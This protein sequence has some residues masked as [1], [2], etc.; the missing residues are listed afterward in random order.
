METYRFQIKR[1]L[2]IQ[3]AGAR[4]SIQIALVVSRAF[5]TCFEYHIVYRG[6]DVLGI[7]GRRPRGF[8]SRSACASAQYVDAQESSSAANVFVN[9]AYFS[10]AA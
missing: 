3:S 5:V 1:I 4:M 9:A 2:L 8:I 7:H 6:I 10:S